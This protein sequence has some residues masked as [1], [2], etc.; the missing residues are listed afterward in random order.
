MTRRDI[1][2]L[3]DDCLCSG[4]FYKPKA[5]GLRPCIVMAHGFGAVKEMRLD[6]YAS[7]FCDAG[8]NVLVFDYRGFGASEG[9]PRRVVDIE[10]QHEDWRAAIVSAREQDQV[11]PER[12]VLWGSSLSGGHVLALAA[13]TS[14]LSG[15]I[16]QVPHIYASAA[17]KTGTASG[18]LSLLLHATWDEGGRILGRTPHY[19][20]ASGR[21]GSVSF[22]NAPEAA[23]YLKL[24]PDGF[25][26]D[27]SVAA[28]AV[29]EMMNYS[30]GR[31]ATK[32]SAP[33]LV[34]AAIN[35][36]TTP[37]SAAIEFVKKLPNGT[38]K[39]YETDH[40]SPYLGE[41][42]E[43]FVADQIAFLKKHVP[44]TTP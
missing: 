38:L 17:A 13:E 40:F 28:R 44:A 12:I 37:A 36:Q 8:Y 25:V 42:F 23:G 29:F 43:A 39:T 41:T 7:R 35:D 14:G 20:P 5:D 11:D 33:T 3:S 31:N 30:P 15:V 27:Q 32:I 1:S 18:K 9:Y 19:L 2:F 16:A 22:M 26:F 21:P 34:Q 24:V 4:W 6:A 10:M